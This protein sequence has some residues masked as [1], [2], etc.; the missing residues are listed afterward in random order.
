MNKKVLLATLVGL[1]SGIAISAAEPESNTVNDR[2]IDLATVP[3][4]PVVMNGSNNSTLHEDVMNALFDS[5]E[6]HFQDPGVPRYLLVDKEGLTALGIGGYVEGVAQ[7][8]FRGAIDANG[9]KTYSI[10]VPSSPTMRSRLGADVTHSTIFLKLIRKTRYGIL[11]AYIQTNFT[12]DNGGYGMKLKQAY[13]SLG[14]VTAGLTNSSFVDP[15]AGVPTIDYQGPSGE[16]SGKNILIRYSNTPSTHFK[17]AVSVE[18]PKA[19]ITSNEFT[20]SINQ[21]V[22]DIPAYVQYQWGTGS[23]LRASA[24]LR[25]LSYRDLVTAEN[26][27]RT[28]YGVQL[29]GIYDYAHLIDVYYAGAYGRGIG[30][31]VNDLSG[32]GM[33]LIASPDKDGSMIAPRTFGIVGGIKVNLGDNFFVSGSYSFNHLYDQEQLGGDT[34]KQ[35]NYVVANAFYTPIQSLQVG[36][37]Y[38][39][40]TRKNVNDES[41]SANRIELMVKYSF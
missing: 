39:H 14:N 23:H 30:N 40:G 19:T 27:I 6:L 7:A 5:S 32:A 33:D 37:E 20:Q 1:T 34:Y 28:G 10:P 31:Y 8:D 24:I 38:L 21:H 2:S 35:A 12:G 9:F 22:P 17:W 16:I 4:H 13:V 25:N 15:S 36:L 41:A 18:M 3:Y 29:S 11:N 26:R